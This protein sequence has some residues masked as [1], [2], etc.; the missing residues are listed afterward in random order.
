MNEKEL[1]KF[2]IEIAAKALSLNNDIVRYATV[3]ENYIL[4]GNPIYSTTN[5]SD[6]SHSLPSELESELEAL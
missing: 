2:C 5:Q 3:I 1:R 6:P 4:N